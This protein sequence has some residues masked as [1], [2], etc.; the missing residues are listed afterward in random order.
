MQKVDLCRKHF[1]LQNDASLNPLSTP[2]T[3]VQLELHELAVTVRLMDSDVQDK[4][5]CTKLISSKWR[6][7]VLTLPTDWIWLLI[8]DEVREKWWQLAVCFCSS[9]PPLI[10]VYFVCILLLLVTK[11]TLDLT[12]Q[13]CYSRK[14]ASHRL[15][16]LRRSTWP[17][18]SAYVQGS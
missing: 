18:G 4:H 16:L 5:T 10:T 17:L 7:N 12:L 13:T 9:H 8:V 3:I 15:S 6:E 11:K 2:Y 14:G 1:G